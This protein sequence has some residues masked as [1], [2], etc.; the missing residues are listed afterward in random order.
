MQPQTAAIQFIHL[1]AQRSL[2]CIQDVFSQ[3]EH[4]SLFVCVCMGLYV[5]VIVRERQLIDYKLFNKLKP[6]G[7]LVCKVYSQYCTKVKLCK[8]T[9][10]KSS[11][12][13]SV[14]LSVTYI[15]IHLLSLGTGAY[16]LLLGMIKFYVIYQH[17]CC[18]NRPLPHC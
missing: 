8:Y 7:A 3:Q 9:L 14:Q 16:K 5:C 11:I 13:T 10:C 12:K 18:A 2:P 1:N 4:S 6:L 15:Y 17:G